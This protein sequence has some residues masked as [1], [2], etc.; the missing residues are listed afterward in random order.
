MFLKKIEK[1]YRSMLYTRPDTRD[2]VFYFS[3][4][5]FSGFMKTPFAFAASAGH[6]LQGYF[7]F[8]GEQRSDRLIVFDH[9]MGGG[10]HRSYTREI[11]TMAKRGYTVFAYDHTGC[12]ES[13]GEST[14][15]FAQSLCDLNDAIIALRA[16]E[17]YKDAEICVVGHSWGAFSSLNIG[18]LHGDIKK[19]V[20][21]SGFSSVERILK[22]NFRGIGR[23][24]LRR[25]MQIERAANPRFFDF[26]AED[27]LKKTKADVLIIHSRDDATVSFDA[28]FEP[29]RKALEGRKNIEFLALD[30]KDHNPNFTREAIAYKNKFF[31]ELT[32][33][34]KSGELQSDEQKRALIESYDWLRMTEQDAELWTKIFEFLG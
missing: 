33:K 4:E 9:G 10:G 14:N 31:A 26:V 22:Q 30:G 8:Y 1:V 25:A 18:A 16:S 32:A 23:V 20:A 5:D 19:I 17:E 27:S 7:Y 21:M 11:E 34:Q 3:S 2:T 12:I 13:G 24:F 15:G 29:M 28:N 6:T